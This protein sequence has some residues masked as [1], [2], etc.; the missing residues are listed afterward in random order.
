MAGLLESDDTKRRGVETLI[1]PSDGVEAYVDVPVSL[2]FR[3][4]NWMVGRHATNMPMLHSTI[5][6]YKEVVILTIMRSVDPLATIILIPSTD[7][8]DD[9]R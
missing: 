7:Q 5:P 1:L 4:R 8:I 6:Q 3:N 9:W 2:F